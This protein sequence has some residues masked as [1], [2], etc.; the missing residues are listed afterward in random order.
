M[1]EAQT[2]PDGVI[3]HKRTNDY[4]MRVKFKTTMMKESFY[5]KSQTTSK[6][7]ATF[8]SFI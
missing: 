3:R 6:V 1:N 5:N 7:I 4:E 8:E 2:R